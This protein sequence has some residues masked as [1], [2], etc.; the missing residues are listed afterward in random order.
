LLAVRLLAVDKGTAPVRHRRWPIRK[1]ESPPETLHQRR[2]CHDEQH[3]RQDS[4][5]LVSGLE[6][7]VSRLEDLVSRLEDLVS[8][9]ED[10]V[11]R[12]EDLVSRLDRHERHEWI[13][14]L[15]RPVV[16]YHRPNSAVSIPQSCS[17]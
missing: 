1:I 6:D 12:L 5:N 14:H 7:L 3:P 8:R 15:R 11:S 4:D 13:G 2:P 16:R 9:L 17:P 10:L